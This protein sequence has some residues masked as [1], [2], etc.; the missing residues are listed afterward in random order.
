MYNYNEVAKL[1]K[2]NGDVL[3]MIDDELSE[4]K[5]KCKYEDKDYIDNKKFIEYIF[6]F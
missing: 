2:H 5:S 1:M 3:R 4:I 6:L